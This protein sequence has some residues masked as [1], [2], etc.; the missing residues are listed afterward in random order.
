MFECPSGSGYL[1]HL[2][3]KEPPCDMSVRVK[4]LKIAGLLEIVL[5]KDELPSLHGE[6]SAINQCGDEVW[7][8]IEGHLDPLFSFSH[9]AS[10][11]VHDAEKIGEP[12]IVCI[13]IQSPFD[14]E[15]GKFGFF[16]FEIGL[17]QG[18]IGA[19]ELRLRFY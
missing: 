1:T 16:I 14:D 3:V 15:L 7:V 19:G 17:S 4:R 18:R 5:G 11:E 6:L 13:L 9:A 8:L 10:F 12:R 2:P